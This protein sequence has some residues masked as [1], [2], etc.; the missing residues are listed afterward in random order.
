MLSEPADFSLES[1]EVTSA[2]LVSRISDRDGNSIL[3]DYDRRELEGAIAVRLA[4]VVY[5][6]SIPQ[7]GVYR[8]GSR[9]VVFDY[10][11][12]PDIVETFSDGLHFVTP[13]RLRRVIVFAPD[14][15]TDGVSPGPERPWWTYELDYDNDPTT[16]TVVVWPPRLQT[17][18]AM[19]KRLTLRATA[20][21]RA[22][23][24]SVRRRRCTWRSSS[25]MRPW[26]RNVARWS[27]ASAV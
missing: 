20:T 21:A 13:D 2:W 1:T 27:R 11:A 15:S 7:D 22:A 17:Y 14:V 5:T 26:P 4:Q 19:N 3:F 9:R 8:P 24:R 10:E 12:R 6:A 25:F 16:S 23:R 18:A